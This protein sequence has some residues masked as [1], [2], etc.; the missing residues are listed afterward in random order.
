M[1]STIDGL[2]EKPV[3]RQWVVTADFVLDATPPAIRAMM[4]R[5]LPRHPAVRVGRRSVRFCTPPN[6]YTDG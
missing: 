2:T 6:R 5:E 4:H 1:K 3:A